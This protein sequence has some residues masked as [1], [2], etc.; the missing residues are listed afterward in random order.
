MLNKKEKGDQGETYACDFL[1]SKGFTII[2]RNFTAGKLELDIIAKKSDLLVFIEVRLRAN[3]SH[4]YP[5]DLMSK[6]KINFVKK[7]AEAY[8]EKHNWK[9]SIRFDFIAI[10]EFPTFEIVHFEDAYF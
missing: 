8:L 5:E 9:G 3:A 1:I 4:G 10:L 7:G 2:E 6:A